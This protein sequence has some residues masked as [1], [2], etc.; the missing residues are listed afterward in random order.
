MRVDRRALAPR[1]GGRH[2]GRGRRRHRRH[3]RPAP[4]PVPRHRGAGRLRRGLLPQLPLGPRGRPRRRPHRRRRHRVD[5]DA[6]HERHR[7]PGRPPE[8]LPAHGP[9]DRP[10]GEPGLR[11][12]DP[13]DVPGRSGT[14]GRRAQQP[15]CRLRG[16]LPRRG[17]SRLAGHGGHR[18]GLPGQPGA[19][20][21]RSRP[22]RAAA[23]RLPGG[24]QAPGAVRRL[25]PGDPGAPGRAGHRADRASRG[26][27]GAHRGRPPPRAGRAGPG[28]RLPHRMPS[29]APWR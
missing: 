10:P 28:H 1:D 6:D 4:S 2:P 27:G 29:C 16:L 20:H 7:R 25:L 11:R 19:E 22:P 3:R 23:A 18:A 12:R 13:P 26:R 21:H 14:P 15:E 17:R 9:V 24:L 5:R 8:P